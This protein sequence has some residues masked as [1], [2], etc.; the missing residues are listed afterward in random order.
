VG[1][2]YIEYEFDE[3][4][5]HSRRRD[6]DPLEPWVNVVW[7]SRVYV[8]EIGIIDAGASGSGNASDNGNRGALTRFAQARDINCRVGLTIHILSIRRLLCGSSPLV[9]IVVV[10]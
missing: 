3:E 2:A 10:Y 5:T 7:L 4:V 6:W 1:G 8:G 9:L